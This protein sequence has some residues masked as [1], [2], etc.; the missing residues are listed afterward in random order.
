MATQSEK[1]AKREVAVRQ[2]LESVGG[3]VADFDAFNRAL[4]AR[5]YLVMAL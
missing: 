2:A 5:G 3:Y 1:N 4:I